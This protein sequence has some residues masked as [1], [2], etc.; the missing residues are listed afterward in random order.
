M[1]DSE[2]K[3]GVSITKCGFFI[4]KTHR[5]LGASPDGII[6]DQAESTSGDAKFKYMY[7]QVK[8]GET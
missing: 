6:T 5:V 7:I 3:K 8:P 4:S 1:L 2:R